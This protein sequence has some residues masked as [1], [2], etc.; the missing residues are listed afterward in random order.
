MPSRTDIRLVELGVVPYGQALSLQY[1]LRD[2]LISGDV[3]EDVAG[4]LICLE[5]EP[6]VTLGKRGLP[7]HLVDPDSLRSQGIEVFE[8]DRGGEATYHGPG[9]LV[10][11]PVI[12]LERLAMGVVDVVRGL[13]DVISEA[14]AE[15]GLAADYDTDH[16]GVWTTDEEPHRKMASVGMRVRRGVSTHGAAI[17]LDNDMRPFSMI[18]PCG[19]PDAPMARLAD[20]TSSDA[21]ISPE[22][23]RQKLYPGIEELTEAT[24]RPSE[25]DLPPQSEWIEPLGDEE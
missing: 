3:P 21:A 22:D 2:R 23:F 14:L 6:V 11:Y 15:Y 24:L 10:V 17:N 12:E 5:H 13:A 7:E 18:V 19:M 1:R 4:W 9:Q 20:Y 16:P 8:I 25:V